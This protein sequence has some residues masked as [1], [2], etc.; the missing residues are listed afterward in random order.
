MTITNLGTLNK[1][2]AN[3]TVNRTAY[4]NASITLGQSRNNS[5]R[6]SISNLTPKSNKSSARKSNNNNSNNGSRRNS[7][8]SNNINFSPT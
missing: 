6:N 8:G 2:N 3:S 7:V 4:L 5:R 1:K